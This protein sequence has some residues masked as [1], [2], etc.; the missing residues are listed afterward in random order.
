MPR[1]VISERRPRSHTLSLSSAVVTERPRALPQRAQP[2]R[3][4]LAR[5]RPPAARS[6]SSGRREG[7]R[8]S[9][10][11]CGTAL[12]VFHRGRHLFNSSVKWHSGSH[13]PL[14]SLQIGPIA[15]LAAACRIDQ[16]RDLSRTCS[17]GTDVP[18]CS[19]PIASFAPMSN[20]A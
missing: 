9:E 16:I 17:W 10:A 3:T 4:D 5:A 14:S 1:G 19:P 20:V 15:W 13:F 12:T 18:P 2:T 6:S 8:L 11:A 7:G